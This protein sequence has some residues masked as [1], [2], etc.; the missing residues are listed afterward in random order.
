MYDIRFYFD[1]G[2]TED[3]Y[4]VNRQTDPQTGISVMERISGEGGSGDAFSGSLVKVFHELSVKYSPTE[5]NMEWYQ[6]VLQN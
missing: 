5:V 2:E 1:D 4:F 3:F 6:T